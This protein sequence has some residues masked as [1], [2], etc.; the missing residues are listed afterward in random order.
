MQVVTIDELDF[1]K[2]SGLM[3]VVVQDY[4]DGSVLTLAYVNREALVKTIE[5]GLAH[6]YRRSHGTVMMKGATS[7]N[8]QRVVEILTD[9][10]LDSL[11]F[12][13]I[14]SGPACH[15]GWESCFSRVVRKESQQTIS[16]RT[17]SDTLVC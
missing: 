13:V 12:R 10:D 11:V 1:A 5:T 14:R 17:S 8:T 3:P 7:G 2:G 6:F 15:L 16:V 9:C 4:T